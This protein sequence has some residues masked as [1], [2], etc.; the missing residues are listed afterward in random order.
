MKQN[1]QH[2]GKAFKNILQEGKDEAELQ[3]FQ[4]VYITCSSLIRMVHKNKASLESVG[5]KLFLGEA[6]LLLKGGKANKQ[7]TP[8]ISV[9]LRKIKILSV[10]T[11]RAQY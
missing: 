3:S 9:L 11:S 5:S 2:S 8:D 4:G 10:A 1:K 7:L 6:L